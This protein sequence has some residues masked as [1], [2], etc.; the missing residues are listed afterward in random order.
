M[1]Q[2][3][4]LILSNDV[5]SLYSCIL[6]E[7]VKGYEINYFYDFR[8]LYQ[9]MT[10][11]NECIGVDID[12]TE[13]YCISNHVTRLSEQDKHNPK[14][15]NLNN[16]ITNDNYKEKYSGSTVLYL[17]R[18]L[19][20][21]LPDTEQGKMI[22][23]AI[24]AS[25]KGFY[26]PDFHAIHKYYLVD[27]LGFEELYYLCQ[28]YTLEDFINLIIKYNLN[29]KIWFNNCGLQTNIKLRELQEVL[30]L[31]FFMPKNKF[32]KIKE[33]EYITKPISNEKTKEELDS[34][35]FSLA[36]TR[37]NYVNYSKLKMEELV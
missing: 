21:P 25:F 20:L 3:Y 4:D 30:K 28:K 31:P 23:L 22:L 16:A 18:L 17:Y 35:I 10:S 24:D 27:I 9:F 5:D 6:L 14:A 19:K 12:L 15:L 34:N 26:N 37:K 13:G 32:T 1:K 11:Q 2:K 8:N 33:F 29:G 36:L 7:Q